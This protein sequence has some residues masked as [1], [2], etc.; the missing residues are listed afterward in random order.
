MLV[1]KLARGLYARSFYCKH[2]LPFGRWLIADEEAPSR[3]DVLDLRPHLVVIFQ[4][5]KAPIDK[6]DSLMRAAYTRCDYI[7]DGEYHCSCK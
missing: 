5:H 6:G 4:S 2:V 1:V 3:I 7:A